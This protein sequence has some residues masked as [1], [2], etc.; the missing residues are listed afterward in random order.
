[1]AEK[2]PKSYIYNPLNAY[3]LIK[4]LT[5]NFELFGKRFAADVDKLDELTTKVQGLLQEYDDLVG[6]VEGL[7]RLQKLY[8]LKSSDFAQ[9]FVD[10]KKTRKEMSAHD[11]FIIGREASKIEY[12]GVGEEY[13]A[14]EY[15]QL[16]VKKF[17]ADNNDIDDVDIGELILLL[18]ATHNRTGN[19]QA[20]V[21]FV[22]ALLKFD[23]SNQDAKDLKQIYQASLETHGSENFKIFNPF[24]QTFHKNGVYDGYKETVLFGKACRGELR[25]T[26]EVQAQLHC[27]YFSASPFSLIAPFKMEEASLKPV[28]VSLFYDMIHVNEI[29]RLKELS[30]SRLKVG[31]VRH[32]SN[33]VV[34]KSRITKTAFLPDNDDIIV[35]KISA[36]VE[37]RKLVK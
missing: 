32:G 11:L 7:I 24:I 16:A 28:A 27:R 25:N 2:H 10:G 14:L 31:T 19:Y 23:E 34:V 29:E 15:L 6:A 22:S 4:R 1:M 26:P 12:E 9:G 33:D 13:I 37:V 3:L 20:A 8:L 21:N 36:R 17:E 30:I 5:A 35:A 18:A